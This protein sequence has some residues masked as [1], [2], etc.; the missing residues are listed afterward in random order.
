M[1]FWKEK[2]PFD[3]TKSHD[4]EPSEELIEDAQAVAQLQSIPNRPDLTEKIHKCKHDRLWRFS[5][6]MPM[7]IIACCD[8]D[9]WRYISDSF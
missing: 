7:D 8:C 1:N 6:G 5:V 2:E 9:Y 3:M 4:F